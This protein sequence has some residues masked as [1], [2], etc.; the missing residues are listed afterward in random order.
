MADPEVPVC[1]G[2][3]STQ[4]LLGTRDGIMKTRWQVGSR[5]KTGKRDIRAIA[6]ALHR[7]DPLRTPLAKR[8]AW[9]D[10]LA[11]IKQALT[12]AKA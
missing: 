9:R 2:G 6:Q 8:Q 12:A 1:L 11:V 3:P 5:I 7:P 10:F 4:T